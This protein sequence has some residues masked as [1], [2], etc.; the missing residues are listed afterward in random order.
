MMRLISCDKYKYLSGLLCLR[1]V[2]NINIDVVSIL[3]K[4][5]Q[6]RYTYQRW[7]AIALLN[8]AILLIQWLNYKM[9]LKLPHE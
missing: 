4:F 1:F 3:W 8:R 2:K 7:I 9:L 6:N 5:L